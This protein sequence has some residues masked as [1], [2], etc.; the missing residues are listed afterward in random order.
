MNNKQL[1]KRVTDLAE[2][3]GMEVQIMDFF[4]DFCQAHGLHCFL[5]YGTLLGAVRHKG[6]IPWDDDIDLMMPRPDYEKML[7]LWKDTPDY[8]ILEVRRTGDYAYPF[9][10]ICNANTYM[11]ENGVI[12]QYDMGLYVDIFVFDALP[13]TPEESRKFLDRTATLEKAR[14]YSNMPAELLLRDG[15]HNWDRRLLWHLLKAV[16]PHR[17]A[18]HM[19]RFNA[20]HDYAAA[21][22]GACLDT[23]FPERETLPISAYAETVQL[24]FEGQTY[25]APRDYELVLTTCYGDY[26]QLPPEEERVLKH[27][28]KLWLCK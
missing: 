10:K 21:T 27:N 11:E 7:K 18:R 2:I 20:S 26:M 22:W 25:P 15:G 3:K 6:F 1:D 4:M 17:I 9:A 19:D 16:G 23:R 13:G 14:M 5:A 28:F 12:G 8:Q 24:E